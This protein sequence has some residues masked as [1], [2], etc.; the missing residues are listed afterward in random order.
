M[1]VLLISAFRNSSRAHIDRWH[2]Q[3]GQ[4]GNALYPV[5]RTRLS[6]LAVEGDSAN[7]TYEMLKS[8]IEKGRGERTSRWLTQYHHNGPHFGS[9]ESAERMTQLSLVADH[10]L[11][12]IR[13]C[14]MLSSS[15]VVIYVESDLIWE[16]STMVALIDALAG[17]TE[18]DVVSPLVFAGE[19]F[20]DVWGFRGLDGSQFAPFPPY[21]SSIPIS[22]DP[23]LVEVSSI[24]S[25]VAFRPV[26][27][28][29]APS[30]SGGAFV[31]W[32]ANVR[33]A[34]HRIAVAP[35]LR[36]HHPA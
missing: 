15:D 10:W 8:R 1:N 32:C 35:S 9:V 17:T 20:Y 3:T 27:A 19:H 18:Y 21:H 12:Y 14:H 2:A 23:H 24:G 29:S 16:A 36:I 6:T 11:D 34:G 13:R 22:A 7:P 25:C 5:N 31:G 26:V 30:M 28:T 33:A 4:L